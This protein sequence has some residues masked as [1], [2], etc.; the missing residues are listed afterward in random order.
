MSVRGYVNKNSLK[1]R[2]VVDTFAKTVFRLCGFISA[3]MIVVIFVFIVQ[4]GIQVFF[5]GY[6][7]GNIDFLSFIS[8]FTWRQD[9]M[10]YGVFFI[11]INTLIT[12]FGAALI[13]FPLSILSA[14][15]I[16]KIVPKRFKIIFTTVIELLAAIPSVV[17]GV[18]AAGVI[19]KWIDSFASA[20]G[21]TTRGGNSLLAV[22]ILLAIMIYPTITTMA[23]TAIEAVP[24]ETEEGSLALG[25]SKTQTYFKV[26]LGSARSGI[27][28]GLV[29]G[30]GRAFGEATAVSMVAGNALVGPT[31]NP[32]DITRTLT[33][34]MLS[35]LKETSGLDYDV[36]FS[37]G[38]VLMITIVITN[39][40][41]HRI[42]DKLGGEK[43]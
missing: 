23:I 19:V 42:K 25:A 14:L 17:Y 13:A 26:I 4:R 28:A 16:A 5:P 40:I 21:Y 18:F 30:L 22:I 12:A 34:T 7:F 15:F 1:R 20:L 11:F 6:Q 39:F 9:Q 35:G 31:L 10:I 41:I 27:V 24:K 3:I 38:I 32:F 37:V 36:R 29:L 43:A 8:G 2:K 33:T